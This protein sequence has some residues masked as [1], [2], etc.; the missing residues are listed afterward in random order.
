MPS[1]ARP[2]ASVKAMSR[3]LGHD[4]VTLALIE[5]AQEAVRE[6]GVV[7]AAVVLGGPRLHD[8]VP[9]ANPIASGVRTRRSRLRTR[10]ALVVDAATATRWVRWNC[11]CGPP[12]GR[13]RRGRRRRPIRRATSTVARRDGDARTRWHLGKLVVIDREADSVDHYRRG[14][15]AGAFVVRADDDRVVTWQGRS[16][17]RGRSS[18]AWISSSAT[19][20]GRRSARAGHDATGRRTRAGDRDDGGPRPTGEEA[21]RQ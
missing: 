17:S 16:R 13:S 6:A 9:T 4:G 19:Y 15:T 14:R 5:P 3:F 21:C 8:P 20:S 18:R 11:V 1:T 2:M 10:T 7:A 12:P